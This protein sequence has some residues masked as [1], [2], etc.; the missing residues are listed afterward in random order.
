MSSDILQEFV[1]ETGGR[2]GR[3]TDGKKR[4]AGEVKRQ[5]CA[6]REREG[7]CVPGE[8]LE[9]KKG[10]VQTELMGLRWSRKQSGSRATGRSGPEGSGQI[11]RASTEHN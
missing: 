5:W 3:G 7:G 8:R 1:C 4:Q 11:P 6:K 2:A 9:R 10:G